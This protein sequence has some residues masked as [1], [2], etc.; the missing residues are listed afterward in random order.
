M[1]KHILHNNLFETRNCCVFIPTFNNQK[2][3]D[4]VITGVLDYTD[5]IIIVNDGAT[6]A[7]ETI[8]SKYQNRLEVITFPKNKGKGVA[9]REGFKRANQ[10]GYDYMITIDSDGQHFPEDLPVFLNELK[11]Q[12]TD[13]PLLLIGSRNMDDPSVPGKSSFG[14]K[15]SNFWYYIETGIKLED[16]Q[17]GFRMYP[18]KEVNKLR[19]FTTKFELEIEVIVKLA[20][21][22]I[23]VRNIPIQVLY[24]ETE[25]VSHFRPFQDF[26]RISILNTWLVTLTLLFYL[27]KRLIARVKKK[28]LKKY[29]KENVLKIN[30]S[31]LK[32]TL[33]IMLGLFIGIAPLWGFQTILVLSLATIL[34]LNRTIAFLFSNIS[35]PP[36]IPFIIYISYQIGAILMGKEIDVSLN[37]ENI[38]S[39]ADVFKSFGQYIIG[40][41]TL[42]IV[43]ALISGVIAYLYFSTRQSKNNAV[44]A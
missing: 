34:K 2:T 5:R 9:L 10:L 27:P 19:L 7:T 15:F 40:S 18:V 20:W 36:L 3:L 24:D 22:G 29:W 12:D 44:D 21:Q 6:D 35:I 31:P 26:T 16:T 32:K 43:V 42:A 1:I 37:I 28:G 23:E 14:N 13:Q 38:K 41:I 11:Q 25:R 8:L 33:A 30:E 4:A 17:S 39:S